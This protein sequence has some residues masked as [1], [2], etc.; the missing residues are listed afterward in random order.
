MTIEELQHIVDGWTKGTGGGYFSPITNAAVLAEETGEVARI[1]ARRYGDQRPKP[2]DRTGLD[3]LADAL[4]DELADLLWVLTA[5]ANQTGID[6]T[7]AMGRN[8][9]KK[10]IRDTDRFKK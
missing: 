5:I 10:I 1:M 8:L 3:D 2:S 7:E 4:A 6:L 9:D